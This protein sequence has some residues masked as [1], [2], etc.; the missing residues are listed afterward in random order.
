MVLII[1]VIEMGKHPKKAFLKKAVP[2]AVSALLLITTMG[3]LMHSHRIEMPSSSEPF[4]NSNPT[5][6]ITI[7]IT[8]SNSQIQINGNLVATNVSQYNYR[9]VPYGLY[10]IVAYKPYYQY[11]SVQVNLSSKSVY[12]N[13]TLRKGTG[14]PGV[15]AQYPWVPI[16]PYNPLVN[17]PNGTALIEAGHLG[18]MAIDQSNPQIMYV[19]T[20][21]S[22][23]TTYGPY[24]DSGIFK[25]TN[26]GKN[27]TPVDFGLP[28]DVVTSLVMNQSNPQEL[29]AGFWDAGIY[30]T[31]DGGGYWYK[32]SNYTATTDMT[33]VNG[34]IY[35]A[36][37]APAFN[38]Y[39]NV[40]AGKDFGNSWKSLLNV[41][42]PLVSLSIS[43][44]YI[45]AV[46]FN[47]TLWKSEDMGY[48]WSRGAEVP[49]GSSYI[50]SIGASPF[51]PNYLYAIVDGTNSLYF[52]TN[53]GSSFTLN[54]TFQHIRQIVFDPQNQ[55]VM[56][57]MGPGGTYV[58]TNGGRSYTFLQPV[59]DEHSMYLL[60]SNPG[61]A[62]VLSDQGI[63]ETENFGT[64][65]FSIN[66][67]LYNF[68]VY[69]FGISNNGTQIITS[70]QD[71]GSILTHD[72][73]KTWGYGY[74][75]SQY[76]IGEGSFVFTNP[77]NN[78]W[79]Y[80]FEPGAKLLIQSNDSGLLFNKAL[81]LSTS[82]WQGYPPLFNSVFAVDPIN[83]SNLFFGSPLG[84]YNG[85]Y[86]GSH[87]N[88]WPG[89]PTNISGLWMDQG[90]TLFV[91][92]NGTNLLYFSNG[93][94][95]KANGINFPV[96]SMTFE[97]TNQ[98][99]ILL[100]SGTSRNTASL[101]LSNNGGS[102]FSL[103]TNDPF[104]LT[105]NPPTQ[106][107]YGGAPIEL[108]Y[109]N[110]T[111]DPVIAATNEGVYLSRD[112]GINWQN[113][114]FNL[115]SGQVTW[116][117]YVNKS[118]YL[119]TYGEGM[120]VWKNFSL[121]N[122]SGTITGAISGVN[123]IGVNINGTDIP[124]YQ[125]HF[126]DYV[127]PGSYYVNITWNGGYRNYSA[128][129]TPLEVFH[130]DYAPEYNITFEEIGLPT[131]TNWSLNLSNGSTYYS[132]GKYI[133]L[134]L[135]NGTYSYTIATTDKTY[136]PSQSSGS[137]SV[138]G[139]SVSRSVSFSEVKYTVTFTE[140]GLPSGVEWY[141]NGTGFSGHKM[142]PAN[143][144]FN[145]ADGTYS[146]TAINLNNY[147]TTTVHFSV[148][149]SGSNVTETVNYYHWAYIAGKVSPTN[150]TVTIN[151]KAVS[152]TSSGSFNVSV[153]NGTYHV[154]ASNS[155]Y[156]PYYNNFTLNSGSSKNLTINLKPISK[157]SAISSTELYAIIG[158]VVAVVFIVGVM[159]VI[160]RR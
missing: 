132:S 36:S 24:G 59:G 88:F 127:K 125:G 67:N 50:D 117:S 155:G 51:D 151:G 44:T 118:L 79:I 29:L 97:P 27:W 21:S 47:G 141:V 153:A 34:T 89:S 94:W 49:V 63:F 90:G 86:N 112:N 69:N 123:G 140:F 99:Y 65:W 137:F 146:F 8:P 10:N 53:A 160:R 23:S 58:S 149:I 45:Y 38:N 7:N 70:M 154:V 135:P 81:D 4:S 57:L 119:S 56:W 157:P 108:F 32:V 48:S 35:A 18:T 66:N 131:E 128:T 25:S 95:Q 31:T 76:W 83:H 122:L 96:A 71:F 124:V 39:G 22:V 54:T 6:N 144:T 91:S 73:G 60:N 104:N 130:A 145:L 78:S 152:L 115:I 139:G 19:G 111:G 87:W 126:V 2:I 28:L 43:R 150:V 82:Q 30:K 5:G 159:F 16:G 93:K 15:N 109:L 107:G 3:M 142:S 17:E 72:G 101:Y 80:A 129:I 64:N 138:N 143:I 98:H 1:L 106:Q 100:A 116:A 133:Y 11:Q 46:S 121:A 9:N 52:S 120:V 33:D 40:I 12:V 14:V 13:F 85:S 148:V 20:G 37:G 134:Q 113:M 84:I 74:L 158:V 41:S 55:S 103:L 114:D 68:L 102:S 42:Y 110:I 156:T 92:S 75:G 136:E 105:F 61:T 62:F 147:Y 77:Y 26:G